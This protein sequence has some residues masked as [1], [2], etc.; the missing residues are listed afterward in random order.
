MTISATVVSADVRD[1]SPLLLD[2]DGSLKVV[3]AS[4]YEN[5][6]LEE[7]GVFG[8]KHALYG[9]LTE[10]LIARLKELIGGRD[11]LEIG[12]GTGALARALGI[13]ATDSWQQTRPDVKSYYELLRQPI[14]QY[15][16]EVE[17]LDAVSAIKKYRPKV[18]VASWVTHRYDPR[19]HS[20]GG[21]EDGVNEE[22]VADHCDAYIFVGNEHVHRNK[23]LWSRPHHIEY[24]AWLYSRALNSS[25]NFIA[26]W[27]R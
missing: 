13:R 20:A 24:P 16:V 23:S 25:R 22:W 8:V 14:I 7:R 26:V 17:R 1:L 9:F 2:H 6:T 10:E 11:A 4:V 21:N 18:V 15:G 27:S 19:R 3:P 12:A 5:T